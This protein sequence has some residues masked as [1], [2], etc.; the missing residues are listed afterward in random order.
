MLWTGKASLMR[1]IWCELNMDFCEE[2]LRNKDKEVDH[3][4][5][6]KSFVNHTKRVRLHP[7]N[8]FKQ[9][10]PRWAMPSRK[11]DLAVG[12]RMITE[13]WDWAVKPVRRLIKYS[14]Q[15]MT[16]A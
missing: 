4:H 15:E 16:G 3:S 14:K 12:R 8:G 13:V 2:L 5:L 11:F 9:G 7:L 10:V 1:E 6:T